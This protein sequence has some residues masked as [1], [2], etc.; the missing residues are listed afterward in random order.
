MFCGK[1]GTQNA[2]GVAFCAGCGAALGGAKKAKK[3]DLSKI[4]INLK[5]RKTL[6]GLGAGVLVLIVLLVLLFSGRSAKGTAEAFMDAMIDADSEA[7]FELVPD[8]V[9]DYLME[10]EGM[11]KRDLKEMYEELDEELADTYE[12][13]E[14]YYGGKLKIT[15]E[16]VDEEDVDKD[17]LEDIKE[18]YEEVDVKVKDAKVFEIKMTMKV[19]SHKET[20]NLELTVIKVGGSWYIDVN[21]IPGF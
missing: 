17:D 7:M 19:G 15:Y 16:I 14:D 21:D 13:M 11:T 4:N 20:Q 3:F 10:E 6:I 2:D 5:D 12:W 9:M 18:L 1:C 8:K